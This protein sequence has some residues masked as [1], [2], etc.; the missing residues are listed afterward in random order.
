MCEYLEKAKVIWPR[1]AAR[2]GI[3]G[4]GPFAILA[5]GNAYL[6]NTRS[7]QQKKMVKFDRHGC[8]AGCVDEHRYFDLTSA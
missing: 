8:G 6:F 5:C 4:T 7:D 3:S 1:C 2:G